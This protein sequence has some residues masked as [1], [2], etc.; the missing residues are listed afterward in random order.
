MRWA[1]GS[2][3]KERLSVGH[4]ADLGVGK[5]VTWGCEGFRAK[6]LTR[7]YEPVR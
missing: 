4:A 7:I 3:L 1:A 2:H 6:A 5:Q